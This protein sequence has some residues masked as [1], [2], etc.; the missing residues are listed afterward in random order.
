[1]T[2]GFPSVKILSKQSPAF[3]VPFWPPGNNSDT[4]AAVEHAAA[5]RAEPDGP[6]LAFSLKVLFG[7]IPACPGPHHCGGYSRRIRES[8]GFCPHAKPVRAQGIFGSIA[9]PLQKFGS[10]FFYVHSD[11]RPLFRRSSHRA[12]IKRATTPRTRTEHHLRRAP[13]ATFRP[14]RGP[15]YSV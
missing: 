15:H 7:N 1:M 5:I 8:S 3:W 2:A 9:R 12:A 11:G 6:R 13:R 14:S 4:I 10:L